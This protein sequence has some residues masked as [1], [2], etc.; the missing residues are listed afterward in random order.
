MLTALAEPA[1]TTEPAHRLDVSPGTVSQHLGALHC[2]GL[3]SRARDGHAVLYLCS[4]LG[5]RL[6]L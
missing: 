5:D 1:G 4:P 3:V 6:C 2:A